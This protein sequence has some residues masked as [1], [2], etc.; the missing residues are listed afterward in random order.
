MPINEVEELILT[1]TP[2]AVKPNRHVAIALNHMNLQR[3]KLQLKIDRMTK[4]RDDLDTAIKA[5]E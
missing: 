2:P 1:P 5:L 3:D 4:E